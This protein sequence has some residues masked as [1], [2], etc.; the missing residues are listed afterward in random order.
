MKSIY[1]FRKKKRDV[2][3]NCLNMKNISKMKRNQF[4]VILNFNKGQKE[5]ESPFHH[6]AISRQFQDEL[7]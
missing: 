4:G 2:H 6:T 7:T 5:E 3:R 1:I